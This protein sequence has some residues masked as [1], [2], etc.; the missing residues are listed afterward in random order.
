MALRLPQNL[1][2]YLML[3][4]FTVGVYAFHG[5]LKH[6]YAELS[7]ADYRDPVALESYFKAAENGAWPTIFRFIL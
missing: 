2:A 4:C 7:R 6:Y 3:F 1:N 5:D